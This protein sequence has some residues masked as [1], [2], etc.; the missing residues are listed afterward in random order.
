MFKMRKA[1]M[2]GWQWGPSAPISQLTTP[3]SES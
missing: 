2:D 1:L 3:L